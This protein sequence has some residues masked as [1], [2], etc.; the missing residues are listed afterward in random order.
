V[1]RSDFRTRLTELAC[2][3]NSFASAAILPCSIHVGAKRFVDQAYQFAEPTENHSTAWAPLAIRC[4]NGPEMTS[5]HFLAW[6]VKR[7]IR[8]F[9]FAWQ[10]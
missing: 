9:G 4:D 2:E 7:K 10:Q 6:C 8:F 1:E 5:R 3:P